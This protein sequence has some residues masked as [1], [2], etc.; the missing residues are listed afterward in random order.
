MEMVNGRLLLK[1]IEKNE[2]VDGIFVVQEEESGLVCEVVSSE[3]NS[4]YKEGQKILL[5]KYN[6]EPVN[7]NNKSY[8]IAF[9]EDVWSIL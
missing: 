7:I 2:E 3:K 4:P 6:T 9:H 1:E 8:L 5:S